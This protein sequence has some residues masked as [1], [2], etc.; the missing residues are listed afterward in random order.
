[1]T[2]AHTLGYAAYF[3]W[4]GVGIGLATAF[5]AMGLGG[6]RGAVLPRWFAILTVVF[7][8]LGAL[9]DAGIPPGGF[10]F[11]LAHR[12]SFVVA[13]SH[14][15]AAGSPSSKCWPRPSP[16]AALPVALWLGRKCRCA[17]ATTSTLAPR[18]A[19]M[20]QIGV[21]TSLG[22]TLTAMM[23]IVGPSYAAPPPGG[24]AWAPP[25]ETSTVSTFSEH[26]TGPDFPCQNEPYTIT[27]TRALGPLPGHRHLPRA[28]P[29]RA[30]RRR[31]CQ[32]H[33]PDLH[34]QL[35]GP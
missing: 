26:F 34:G 13:K 33:R 27:A 1:M 16:S 21:G 4:A 12:V 28:L 14:R 25:T 15:R 5:I 10:V 23:V 29:Q 3:G 8:V 6:L 30:L 18:N 9:G 7:G 22:L 32:R 31:P 19:G 17:I 11:I 35:L 2:A 20:E 24:T